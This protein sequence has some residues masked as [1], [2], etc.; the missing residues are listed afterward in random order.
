VPEH[1]PALESTALPDIIQAR[2]MIRSGEAPFLPITLPIISI[3]SALRSGPSS[4][5]GRSTLLGHMPIPIGL[6]L[7]ATDGLAPDA[8]TAD[9]QIRRRKASLGGVLGVA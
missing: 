7:I 5:R 4:I 1:Q 3:H 2:T 9:R 8:I 6:I